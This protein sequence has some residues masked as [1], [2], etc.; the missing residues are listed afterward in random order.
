MRR[1]KA[2]QQWR[3]GGGGGRCGIGI[4]G[5][6]KEEEEESMVSL[7]V[8]VE[9]IRL[10]SVVSKQ[11][12]EGMAA[13]VA[14]RRRRKGV[15]AS[16]ARRRRAWRWWQWQEGWPGRKDKEE[17]LVVAVAMRKACGQGQVGG[18][19]NSNGADKEKGLEVRTRR[20]VW[21][22]RRRVEGSDGGDE[23]KGGVA[24]SAVAWRRFWRQR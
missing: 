10:G 7:T 22:R 11:V 23:Q 8:A 12:E 3:Q 20:R 2:W 5:V 24:S 18:L 14:E 4:C 1:R 21:Q 19:G 6:G 9:R 15:L 13:T 16:T 17:G